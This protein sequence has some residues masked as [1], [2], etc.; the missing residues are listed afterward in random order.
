MENIKDKYFEIIVCFGLT[1][2]G[3]YRMLYFNEIKEKEIESKVIIEFDETLIMIYELSAILFI[4]FTTETVK[5]IYL[6]IYLIS[7]IYISYRYTLNI[8]FLY[9]LRKLVPF[10][11]TINSIIEHLV[12]V[13]LLIY[14]IFIK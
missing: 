8:N 11:S 5:K 9:E 14:I 3:I 7:A 2:A 4:F 1:A 12:F 10:T 6:L 13:I